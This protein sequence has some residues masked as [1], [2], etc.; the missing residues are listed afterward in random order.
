MTF[1]TYALHCTFVEPDPTAPCIVMA[2]LSD[3]G[4]PYYDVG[5]YGDFVYYSSWANRSV[6]VMNLHTGH[7][8][9]VA[10]NL[11]RPTQFVIH[12][13]SDTSGECDDSWC[14]VVQ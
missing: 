5:V 1:G 6:S 8:E 12:H 7:T 14:A 10:A 13:P 3:G 2:T 4:A 9:V 11:A